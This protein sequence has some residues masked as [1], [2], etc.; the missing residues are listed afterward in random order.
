MFS[1]IMTIIMIMIMIVITEKKI[2]KRYMDVFVRNS[3][4]GDTQ[5]PNS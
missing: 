3:Y 4:H 5:K 2:I 1:L